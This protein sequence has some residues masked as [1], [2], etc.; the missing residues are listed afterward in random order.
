MRT[1][2]GS[3]LVSDPPRQAAGV[4]DGAVLAGD[5]DLCD[6]ALVIPDYDDDDPTTST[7]KRR[8]NMTQRVPVPSS[9]HVAEIVGRQGKIS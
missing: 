7:S 8:A 9:E 6:A 5:V 4:V 1:A 3:A 2:G